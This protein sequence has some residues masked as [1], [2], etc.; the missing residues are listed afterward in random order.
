MIGSQWPLVFFFLFN[1]DLTEELIAKLLQSTGT[2]V[3]QKE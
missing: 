3:K 2:N 1:L